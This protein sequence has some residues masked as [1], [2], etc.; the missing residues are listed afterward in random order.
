MLRTIILTCLIVAAAPLR[1]A[2]GPEVMQTVS[3]AKS[4]GDLLVQAVTHLLR[5]N[6]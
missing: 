3:G 4:L 6:V 1:A 5:A 2:T